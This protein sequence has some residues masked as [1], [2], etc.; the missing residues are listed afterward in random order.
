M[1]SPVIVEWIVRGVPDVLRASRNVAD[2]VV[3][4]ERA[5]TRAVEREA[6]A[7][8]RLLQQATRSKE[9]AAKDETRAIEKAAQDNARIYRQAAN[10]VERIQ[11]RAQRNALRSFERNEEAKNRAAMAWVRKREQAET[12]AA[13]QAHAARMRFATA[14]GGSAASG[15]AR[16][17][18]R[19]AGIAGRVG[20]LVTQLGGGFSV[21]DSV[22]RGV[23]LRHDA[24]VLS[25]S[26]E[27]AGPTARKI[28]TNEIV[29]KARAI[30]AEQGIDPAEVLKGFDEVK[31]LTGDLDKAMQIMPGIA[32]LAT[33][34]GGKLSE[35]SGLAANILAS[36]PSISNKDLDAQMRVFT[37]QGVVGGVEV[38]D[39][40]KY[41]SRLTAGASLFG[42]DSSKNQA[43]LGAIA[44]ISR[45]YGGAASPAEATLAAQRF[46]TDTAKH[47][48]TLKKHG[49][50]V[51]DGQGNL[52]DAQTILAEMVDKTGGDV[53]KLGSMG[54]GERGVKA[55]TGVSA[56]YKNAGGGDKGRDAVKQ[57][58][59]KYTTGVSAGEVDTASKRVLGEADAKMEQIR[60]KFDQAVSEKLIPKLLELIPVLEKLIPDFVN[61]AATA[62]P[63][64][65]E[66]IKSVSSFAEANKGLISDIAAHPIGSIMAFE[67]GK[68]IVAANIGSVIKS[69]LSGGGV[70]P[71][72]TGGIGGAGTR[73]VLG[74][75]A[76]G[77]A[78]GLAVGSVITKA[79]E[80]YANGGMSADDLAAK[81]RAY[82]RG[83]HERGVSPEMAAKQVDA[84]QG[85][86]N[87]GSILG[88]TGD[89]LGSLVGGEASSKAYSQTKA[90]QG[91]VDSKELIA[92]LKDV[93]A[94]TRANATTGVGGANRSEPIVKRATQ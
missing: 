53:T 16:G 57:E 70:V 90:D 1:A 40:A 54:L 73:G 10:E 68:S 13:Q 33:A 29:S 11:E 18:G 3:A 74:A 17:A 48:G 62:M 41:G 65:V 61:L 32:K 44:Q 94:A 4:S 88:T 25:A 77:V 35:M 7:R 39:F 46:A 23:S 72:A 47:A 12:Q 63:A 66:L 56:I 50:N 55:L 71:G 36:N 24:A 93:A 19:V 78:A 49:I 87:K 67:V 51:S 85:R 28:G 20:G 76:A 89:L 59:A 31:K 92:A 2:A 34:T 84:A 80:G 9:R 69:L 64:F 6:Q 26:T 43:T 21:A 81:V 75:G 52:K 15:M 82:G 45:Q 30:G 86:L 91:L 79:G 83:D 22:Q 5:A 8:A 37:R 60:Q 38:A 42:G 27:L 14:I 58:F